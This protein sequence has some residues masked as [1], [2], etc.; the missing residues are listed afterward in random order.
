MKMFCK[1]VKFVLFLAC[2]LVF[3]CE[4][5]AQNLLSNGDFESTGGYSSAYPKAAWPAS[6]PVTYAI[7]V[8]A[9]QINPRWSDSC[10]DHT[11]GTGNM[12]LVDG[13]NAPM[14]SAWQPETPIVVIPGVTYHFSFWSA[15][16]SRLSVH[17]GPPYNKVPSFQVKINDKIQ[18]I[19]IGYGDLSKILGLWEKREY[20]WTADTIYGQIALYNLADGLIGNDFALDDMVFEP[21][22]QPLWIKSSGTNPT[23]PGVADGAIAVYGGGGL[24]PYSYNIDGG[25]FSSNTIFT[26]L[27]AGKGH[28][29]GIKD[30]NGD[31]T[32]TYFILSDPYSSLSINGE[33][34][35]CSGQQTMLTATGGSG[36]FAWTANPLDP[37]LIAT[38]IANPQVSPLL[39]T[40][41]AVS[42]PDT[43]LSELIN[44]GTFS[45]DNLNFHTDYLQYTYPPYLN[46]KPPQKAYGLQSNAYNF[47]NTFA[48]CND[49]SGS[50]SKMLVARGSSIPGS[51]VWMQK[52]LVKS[53]TSYVFSYWV[54]SVDTPN[55]A[56]VETIVNGLPITGASITSTF[57]ASDTLCQWV[58]VMYNWYSGTD[59]V[60]EIA[61]YDRDTSFDG[62][63]FALDNISLTTKQACVLSK[64]ITVKVGNSRIPTAYVTRNPTCAAPTG[65]IKVFYPLGLKYTY[66][67]DSVNYNNATGIF[68][69]L[70]PNLYRVTAKDSSG[71][72][73]LTTILKIDTVPAA[74][75]PV[76]IEVTQPTCSQLGGVKILS[77]IGPKYSYSKNGVT[78]Q[79]NEQFVQLNTGSYPITAKVEYGGCPS[80]PVIAVIDTVPPISFTFSLTTYIGICFSKVVVNGQIKPGYSFT[81]FSGYRSFTNSTGVF[82][83]VPGPE[84]YSLRVQVP[85]GCAMGPNPGWIRSGADRPTAF[86]PLGHPTCTTSGFIQIDWPRDSTY[87]FSIDGINFQSSRLFSNLVSG[88]Y[89]IRLKNANG[90]ISDSVKYIL[91]PVPAPPDSPIVAILRQP[92]CL[93]P[94]GVVVIYNP[95]APGHTY[96]IDGVNYN[97][98]GVFYD[99]LP[100]TYQLTVKNKFG[101]VSNPTSITINT[102]TV[103]PAPSLQL[104]QPNCDTISGKIIINAPKGPGLYYSIN[105]LDFSN[106][107]GSF[108]GLAP[109]TYSVSVKNDSGCVSS[110]VAVIVDSPPTIPPA[111]GI[112]VLQPTCAIP[113]GSIL[114]NSPIGSGF[115][116]SIN[117]NAF[118]ASTTFSGLAPGNYTVTTKYDSGCVSTVTN[119]VLN[120]AIPLNLTL[121]A[122]PN[123]VKQG[124]KVQFTVSGNT[125][126]LVTAWLPINSFPNQNSLSQNIAITSAGPYSVA[127]KAAGACTDTTSTTIIIQPSFSDIFIPNTFTPNGDGVNDELLV[128]GNN[129]QEIRFQ[130]FNQSGKMVFESRDQQ[131]GWDGQF[132]G[133]IQPIGV[134]LFLLR[135]VLD[136]KSTINRK[137]SVNLIR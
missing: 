92:S 55:P 40:A 49:L 127:G 27:A 116:Y 2:L 45:L 80:T 32:K 22:P 135:V 79:S 66:S 91:N 57:I 46:I 63:A 130:I 17:T 1:K 131:K 87:S 54:Q 52:V 29:M 74:P 108:Y 99:V 13:G 89:Y 112:D 70:Q 104:I 113:T 26:K 69:G 73:S 48:G 25:P 83:S 65:D 9:Q 37:T 119:T 61:L 56:K 129:I 21:V 18:L 110:S 33:Q 75:P 39:T 123:S 72:V 6:T 96:S 121:S 134:Y 64:T 85:Y 44:D 122:T 31:T 77:P 126:F 105:G 94:K 111:P 24:P 53:Q 34:N 100:G 35:I 106:T 10:M 78:Y 62:N 12:M 118:S 117:G 102:P 82:D 90:C 11:S 68:T 93:N 98:T 14:L 50:Y 43:L 5:K 15:S 81:L 19:A 133:K 16:I 23:C 42:S 3:I 20:L 109:G 137:G 128:Y 86:L 41:Y 103:I 84:I 8:N 51:I 60:A 47:A 59:T 7:G 88:T 132:K 136:D 67:I 71:C 4:T 38:G 76:T 114:V 30:A 36:K 97:E 107:T 101:C 95:T 125:P 120:A 58:Q 124:D 115:S 28:M